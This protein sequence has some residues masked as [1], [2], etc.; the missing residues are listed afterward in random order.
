MDINLISYDTT[1]ISEPTIT[2]ITGLENVQI[3]YFDKHREALEMAA[4]NTNSQMIEVFQG[5]VKYS[6]E[7]KNG[8]IGTLR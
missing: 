1:M 6:A 3:C 4:K 2:R 5:V 8:K 7:I